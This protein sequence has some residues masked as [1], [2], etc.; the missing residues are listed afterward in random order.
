[1]RLPAVATALRFA[2]VVTP[3]A[4][5]LNRVLSLLAQPDTGVEETATPHKVY[6]PQGDQSWAEHLIP[7]F[8]V[9]E[10][11]LCIQATPS[12]IRFTQSYIFIRFTLDA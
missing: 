6:T 5:R 8:R 10:T 12:H 7:V 1:M 2:G 11:L 4:R 9:R 3:T